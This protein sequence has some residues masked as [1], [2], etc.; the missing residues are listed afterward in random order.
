[1]L[2]CSRVV[3]WAHWI[4]TASQRYTGPAIK[5]ST[6][7]A[8]TLIYHSLASPAMGHWGTCPLPPPNL[9]RLPSDYFLLVTSEPHQ[10]WHWTLYIPVCGRLPRKNQL[11]HCLL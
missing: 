5:V 1:M 8:L 2:L 10:H 6:H 3:M 11:C 4:K 9:L 7:L